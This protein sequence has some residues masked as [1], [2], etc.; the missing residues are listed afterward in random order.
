MA[1]ELASGTRLTLVQET[2]Y[3]VSGNITLTVNPSRST[4]FTLQLRIPY[5]SDRTRVLVNQKPIKNV[6]AGSYCALERRW[7]KGDRVE[8]RLDMSEHFWIGEKECAGDTSMYRGPILM[9][10]DRRFNQVDPDDIPKLDARSLKHRSVQWKGRIP[11]ILLIE[12]RDAKGNRLTLCDFGSAGE[13][14]TPYK[15]WLKFIGV[16]KD[17]FSRAN[18]LRSARL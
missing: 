1:A 15:S 17:C 4:T 9:T 7:Q 8:I 10:Y 16:P 14:G 18:P 12:Y 3:P 5:W 11:P 2:D 6:S 13:G